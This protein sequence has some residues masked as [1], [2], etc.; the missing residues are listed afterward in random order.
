[1]GALDERQKTFR[2]V[3]TSLPPAMFLG[4]ADIT[5]NDSVTGYRASAVDLGHLQA[6]ANEAFGL[7][8]M[9]QVRER[10]KEDIFPWLHDFLRG[11]VQRRK[12][13]HFDLGESGIHILLETQDDH[14]YYKYEFD[15]FPGK[16]R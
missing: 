13:V 16:R 6:L 9:E 5:V 4:G 12:W 3:V 14:G 1:M 7:L 8:T 10:W 11:W 15:I 2:Q